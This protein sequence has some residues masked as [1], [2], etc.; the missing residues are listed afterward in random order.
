MKLKPHSLNNTCCNWSSLEEKTEW[1]MFPLR[2]RLRADRRISQNPVSWKQMSPK[3]IVH[4]HWLFGKEAESSI[5][6]A[7]V[8]IFRFYSQIKRVIPDQYC[9]GNRD[10][11]WDW[12]LLVSCLLGR[13]LESKMTNKARQHM[14]SRYLITGLKYG[15]VKKCS[16][17]SEREISVNN[18]RPHAHV[19]VHQAKLPAQVSMAQSQYLKW[20][21]KHVYNPATRGPSISCLSDT[22]LWANMLMLFTWDEK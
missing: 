16:G 3:S 17:W 15:E 18:T 2:E 10:K 13:R 12:I 6:T 11:Q 20:F 4:S 22:I 9:F 1:S 7:F 14:V 8:P 21:V 19:V 5:E